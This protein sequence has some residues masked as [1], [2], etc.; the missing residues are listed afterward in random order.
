MGTLSNSTRR[1]V[2]LPTN[3]VIPHGGS[4]DLPD[5]TVRAPDNWPTIGSLL[6]AGDLAWESDPEPEGREEDERPPPPPAP[7][8]GLSPDTVLEI[9]APGEPSRAAR[10][11]AALAGLLDDQFTSSGLPMV[12]ALNAVLAPDEERVTAAER[13]ALWAA[14]TA[15]ASQEEA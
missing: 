13:D 15:T 2:R 12:E 5:A 6:A 9:D 11:A 4:L 8:M 10:L 14:F 1:D 7:A 3:H